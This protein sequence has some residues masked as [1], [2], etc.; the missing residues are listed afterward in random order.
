MKAGTAAHQRRRHLA[1]LERARGLNE[2]IGQARR[3]TGT[4]L[5]A[6]LA[7]RVL[8]HLTCDG[9]KTLAPPHPG[10]GSLGQTTALG[11]HRL[12]GPLGHGHQNLRQVQRRIG[13]R[14]TALTLQVVFDVTVGQADALVNLA[15]PGALNQQLVAQ[16]GPKACEIDALGRQTLAQLGHIELVLRSHGLHCTVQLRIVDLAAGVTR[17]GQDHALLDQGFHDLALQLLLGWHASTR[18]LGIFLRPRKPPRHFH[19]RHQLLID[20]GHDVIA[21]AHRGAVGR[22]VGRPVG[23]RGLA[24]GPCAGRCTGGDANGGERHPPEAG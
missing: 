2:K 1:D 3:R 8:R 4:D 18:A 7:L 22:S 13:R 5:A 10:Q 19:R 12:A 20:D 23:G 15:L 14:G 11:H 21:A 9:L 16:V 17:M 6:P 24:L